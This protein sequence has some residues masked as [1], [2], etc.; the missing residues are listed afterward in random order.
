LFSWTAVFR[1]MLFHDVERMFELLGYPE[2]EETYL[3]GRDGETA[4]LPDFSEPVLRRFLMVALY[5]ISYREGSRSMRSGSGQGL[6]VPS[7]RGVEV[8]GIG[9][10]MEGTD[11]WGNRLPNAR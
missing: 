9:Q 8:R 11:R 7:E 6:P 4:F 1:D 10:I 5:R 3:S 2:E